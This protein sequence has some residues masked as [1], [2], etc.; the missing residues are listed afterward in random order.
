M[1]ISIVT[2]TYNSKTFIKNCLE[3]L[4]KIVTF[5][6]LIYP[7]GLLI[8]FYDPSIETTLMRELVYNLGDLFNKIGFVIICFFC[9][10]K[11]SKLSN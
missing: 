6:W 11:L 10:V 8:S 5:G 4:A 7:A 3:S 1:K 2:V 9:A